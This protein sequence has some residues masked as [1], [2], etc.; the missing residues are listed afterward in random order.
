MNRNVQVAV[1]LAALAAVPAA[2]RVARADD[3]PPSYKLVVVDSFGGSQ[4]QLID[5]NEDRV[6]V[7]FARDAREVRHP[8]R[9]HHGIV[10]QLDP[11]PGS[12]AGAA[13]GVNDD[14]DICG[15]SVAGHSNE[16][17]LWPGARPLDLGAGPQ[18]YPLGRC[19]YVRDDGLAAGIAEDPT[20]QKSR[21][22]AFQHGRVI[23]FSIDGYDFQFV[24]QVNRHGVVAAYGTT[25]NNLLV[26]DATG[27]TYD[28]RRGITTIFPA[29]PGDTS[30]LI[31]QITDKGKIYGYSYNDNIQ[32][33]VLFDPRANGTGEVLRSE[34]NGYGQLTCNDEYIVSTYTG[35]A[36]P[37]FYWKGQWKN[38]H[39]RI[40]NRDGFTISD[41]NGINR[42][43][44]LVGQGTTK[45]GAI[46]AFVLLRQDD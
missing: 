45:S 33:I 1:A 4:S 15:W 35:T 19:Y 34:P 37:L 18:G 11:L 27:Y 2:A 13:I 22:I 32:N 3:G 21:A 41:V 12:T 30:T 31:S 14:G 39:D 36:E 40:R 25:A 23:D 38:L 9:W 24:T 20:G 10:S 42:G 16:P 46:R 26:Q 5:I 29:L 44:D 43:G 7:G 6:A 28:I 17:T 8:L